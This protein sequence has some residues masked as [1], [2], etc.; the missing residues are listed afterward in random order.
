MIKLTFQCGKLIQAK[1][2]SAVNL[3][4]FSMTNEILSQ[5][6]VEGMDCDAIVIWW[7]IIN[8]DRINFDN[9]DLFNIANGNPMEY[10]RSIILC[11]Q[12][13]QSRKTPAYI[14]NVNW[15]ALRWAKNAKNYYLQLPIWLRNLKW[16][17]LA[18][19]VSI[20]R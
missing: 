11:P 12:H 15:P 9:C 20:A 18:G 6:K 19:I 8:S 2:R 10:G 17:N 14:N 13:R 7:T 16:G 4:K 1:D 5:W 3:P